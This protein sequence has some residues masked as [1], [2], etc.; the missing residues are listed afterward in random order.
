MIR[1][2]VRRGWLLV[3]V[4]A[5]AL[6]GGCHGGKSDGRSA[7]HAPEVLASLQAHP[8]SL[9]PPMA[10]GFQT[11]SGGYSP[12][13]S[14]SGEQVSA[15]VVLPTRSSGKTHLEDSKTG[16]AVD[17]ALANAS[18]AAAE[19][20]EGYVVYPHGHASGASLIHRVLPSGTEDYLSFDAAPSV[21]EVDYDVTLGNGVSGLRLVSGTLEML[22]AGGAPRLRVAPPY[23][24]GANGARTDATLA[25][26]GCAVDTNPAGPWGR[27]VTPPG[28]QTCTVRVTWPDG[29]VVYPAVLDPRWTNTGA[30]VAAR[31]DHTATLLSNNKILVAGGRASSTATAAITTNNAELFDPATATWSATAN[32]TARFS[33]TATQLNTSSN[34]TTSGMVLVAGGINNS[35]SVTTAQFYS[36]TTGLW[37][38]AASLSPARHLHTATLMPN[39]R[40]LVAGGMTNTSVLGSAAI[41][42]PTTGTGTWT[43][44]STNM[45]SLRRSHTATLL[46]SSN[47]N[48]NNKV[49][50]VGGNSGGT[51]SLTT[52]QLFDTTALTWSTTTA[53][54]PAREG[55]TAT[56]LA[57][58]N[59]LITGGKNV[60][61]FLGTAQ[62]FTIPAS[63]TAATWVSAGTM[64]ALRWAHTA[65][66]LSTTVL[67]NGSVLVVGGSNGTNP[68]TS[69]DLW[70]GTTT[71]T[72]TTALTT[73]VQAHTATLLASGGVVIAGGSNNGTASVAAAVVYDPSFALS[74]STNSQCATGFCVNGVC[75]DTACNG[76]CGACN[77][78]GKVGTCSPV[79]N[80]TTC[81]D[82][83]AC[84]TGETCQSGTCTGGTTVTCT[85][86][87]CHTIGTCVAATGC[88]APVA[89]AN[90]TTCSD[91][92]ACTNG[93][94]CQS[95]TC[96]GG[97]T[98]TCTGADTCHTVGACVPATGCPA[99][100]SKANGTTCSDSNACTSGE[101]C[102]SGTC[103]GGTT[104]TCTGADTCHTVGACVPATGC[105]APVTKVNGTT[106][107]D[108]NACTSGETCQSGTCTGGTAVTCTG[109]DTCHTVG[110]CVPATGCPAPVTKANGTICNDSN[111][112]TSGETCQSGT[113]TGGTAVTCTTDQ[114]HTIGTCVA[115]TGCPAPVLKADGSFCDDGNACTQTDACVAGVCTGSNPITCSGAGTDPCRS[116]GA[117]DPATGM[118]STTLAPDNQ[119]CE[120]GNR[121]TVNDRC[122]KGA[123]VPGSAT[124][125]SA[126]DTHYTTVIDL[127]SS[128]GWSYATDINNNHEVVGSDVAPTSGFIE[129]MAPGSRAFTWTES[130]G[131][132]Y[133]PWPTGYSFGRALNDS[134]VV[135]LSAGLPNQGLLPCRY[136]PSTDTAPVCQPFSGNG[137]GI[138]SGGTMTGGIYEPALQMFR[139]GAGAIQLLPSAPGGGQQTFGMG[140]DT[141]GTVVGEQLVMPT[142]W[143]AVRY[144]DNGGNTELLNSLPGADPHWDLNTAVWIGGRDI[145]AYGSH[146]GFNRAALIKT[147]SSGD[148]VSTTD[149]GLPPSYALDA[150]NCVIARKE[151]S[152]GE[153]VGAVYDGE[154]FTAITATLYTASTG[155]IDLND[156][157]DPQSGW[158][159]HGAA[160]I[161]ESHEV[162]GVGYLNDQ[163]RA[164]K[165]TL[166]D[167]S[168]CPPVTDGCHTQGQRD[169]LTRVC[170]NPPVADG[171]TCND[172][173][174]CT[175][176]ET[177]Q[178]GSCTSGTTVI[179]PVTDQCRTGSG[180]CDPA[181]GCTGVVLA[182]NGTP[183]NDGNAC[184]T[185]DTCQA[186][187]C[188]GSP[189]QCGPSDGCHAPGTCD[190][191]SGTCRAGAALSGSC[192]LGVFDYDKAGRLIHDRGSLMTYD[193]YD[194]LRTVTPNGAG[195]I[196]SGL[197]VEEIGNIDG[198]YANAFPAAR[199]INAKAHATGWATLPSGATHAYMYVGSGESIDINDAANIQTELDGYGITSNDTVGGGY[200]D[201]AGVQH[202]FTY[203]QAQG[204]K[205]LGVG[206]PGALVNP[207]ELNDQQQFTGSL[208]LPGG[209]THGF[210]FTPGSG[211]ED[212]GTLGG[213]NSFGYGID[214][215][216]TVLSSA[217]TA[218]SPTT[219]FE[220][221]GHATIYNTELG[222]V[223]LN[224]YVDPTSSLILVTTFR[225]AGNWI[226]GTAVDGGINSGYR[227]NLSTGMVDDIAV[228]NGGNLF[229][230]GINSYGE[231]VGDGTIDG[232]TQPSAAY[233]FTDA[234]GLRKLNDLIDPSSGWNL[235]NALAIDDEGDVV[236]TGYLNGR[237]AAYLLRLPLRPAMGGA[238]TIAVAHSYGYDG[239]RTSTTNGPGTTGA[240]VQFWFTQ[241]YTQHDGARDH[242]VRVGDRIV[243][244]VTYNPPPGG[245][246]GMG[247][248]RRP[249]EKPTDLG[250]LIAKIILAL[251]LAGG[252]GVS[253]AGFLGKKRR[254]AWVA[255]TAGPVALFFVASCEMLGLDHRQSAASL[256]QR[257]STV[258][259]H[260]GIGPG[261]VLT[262]NSDGSLREERRYEPFGQPIDANIGQGGIGVVDFRR[263]EQNSLGKLTDP[264][265]GWSYHGARWMQPQ[266]AK[267]TAP[268]PQVRVPTDAAMADFW[269]LNPYQYG[270]QNPTLFWDPDGAA[271]QLFVVNMTTGPDALSPR[272]L[273]TVTQQLQSDMRQIDPD[274]TV[275]VV[276]PA[277]HQSNTLGPEQHALVFVNNDKAG[278]AAVLARGGSPKAADVVESHLKIQNG[279]TNGGTTPHALS[280][281]SYVQVAPHRTLGRF[282]SRSTTGEGDPI[283]SN[284]GTLRAMGNTGAHEVAHQILHGTP[285]EAA[286]EKSGDMIPGEEHAKSGILSPGFNSEATTDWGAALGPLK[287]EAAKDSAS[288]LPTEAPPDFLAP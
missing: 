215:S 55:H 224:R 146:D 30:M 205:D 168:P 110:A 186:G 160:G 179:C 143:E 116:A 15:R 159:L 196:P 10:S 17:V 2:G 92:N 141:D 183:C 254:P 178:A 138:N 1:A 130:G 169:P 285:S 9:R 170:S 57:N 234:L 265:T 120:D 153:I 39:G 68:V 149:L 156:L 42:N 4:S 63:G 225:S 16:V 216:G 46:S 242:Y 43:A 97:T 210:R 245:M 69:A 45:S 250:D 237:F 202:L 176:G 249:G 266:T 180:T 268:D 172:G 161:N 231:V 278:H 151:N 213:Q 94:T 175:T 164:F 145:L 147:T 284:E 40:V 91:S 86:D 60:S 58:G 37:T 287:T 33:A 264:A 272:E 211:Y 122:E 276:S 185:G 99:P 126:G 283:C 282:G 148:V 252:A 19:I 6:S 189:I 12:Q 241:D 214:D 248:V 144:S 3:S 222:L 7:Q 32:M 274:A 269:N 75:C 66:L 166:P 104:V 65:T 188:G 154:C 142:R 101:T 98:V 240:S 251:M 236:G 223:D 206:P 113:C 53:L 80:G 28:A 190:P 102:Q 73:A 51:T 244:K 255:A 22:D 62:V 273:N 158:V 207:Q 106:C 286:A 52:V 49:L 227:L 105:P 117:C 262:T 187:S 139:L 26:A 79:A 165:M 23:L 201:G 200:F 27:P 267:W 121:C 127:G 119:A 100:V 220:Q 260:N 133:L 192:Q 34:S 137:Y 275:E 173:N 56:K 239:L 72:A 89:K 261:P 221:F 134:G 259:F 85:T 108:S 25:V 5:V 167:L 115:A 88:P 70:N 18:S 82:S 281:E 71:W 50:I 13:F 195:P 136:D 162:V 44:V 29:A 271:M 193:G 235:T 123:C 125:C 132:S 129:F 279:K 197:A 226:S 157:I 203:S 280:R 20:S 277:S 208:T 270:G 118:C 140:I 288:A 78:T 212:I 174:A 38:T 191:T 199:A 74:C 163:P 219:G 218:T 93:E 181:T 11:V 229:G 124:G 217:Q 177:C 232:P 128:Q 111:A 59:V 67:D 204:F 228:N 41:Y 48:F 194:Q 131:M 95:G 14:S 155:M 8:F 256:W 198:S 247:L 152:Q 77:L 233:I 109:A 258:Y 182:A 243:A 36:A 238:P 246:M 84:T 253:A 112:C 209:V 81:S 87:Q 150:P 171:T 135:S 76:G 257:V 24:V 35:A 21:P 47:S 184:S 107:D 114:C 263:E 90:G 61:T 103:T 31:Q 96:T 83:N 64:N 54:S 230:F